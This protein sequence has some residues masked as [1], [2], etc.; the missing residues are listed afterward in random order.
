MLIEYMAKKLGLELSKQ[1]KKFSIIQV[2][3][4]FV[5][6]LFVVYDTPLPSEIEALVQEPFGKF[7]LLIVVLGSF[8]SFGIIVGLLAMLGAYEILRRAGETHEVRITNKLMNTPS[9]AY[10]DNQSLSAMNQ[11]PIT[12]EEEVIHTMVPLAKGD[13]PKKTYKP[14][15]SEID[16]TT[17]Y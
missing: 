15:V 7:I 2:V 3:V 6:L 8:A 1:L 9:K 5:V 14:T 12:L 17:E 4:L 13:L 11:F 10:D 16:G